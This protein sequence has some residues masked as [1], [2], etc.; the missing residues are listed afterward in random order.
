MTRLVPLMMLVYFMA[1]VDRTNVSLAKT[2]LEADLGI[3]AAAYGFGA[4]IFFL[5]YALLEIP[6]NLILHKVGA[7][8]WIA[9][10]AVTW[11]LLTS[12]TMFVDRE[13]SFYL[14][15]FLLGAAEAGLY[16]G[17]MYMITLWF[18]HKDRSTAVGLMMLAATSAFI[19]GNPAGGAIMGLDGSSG[20]HGWQWLFLLEGLVTVLVGV[21]IWFKLPDRPETASWLTAE[22]AAALTGR[23]VGEDGGIP[24]LRGN[25][26]AAFGNRV[27]L[28]AAAIY[29]FTQVSTYGATFF[30]PSVVE[31]MNVEGT[32]MIGLVAG[33]IAFG[34]FGGA[35]VMPRLHRRFGQG[36][37]PGII[38]LAS[39]G[40]LIA[41]AVFV[42]TTAPITRLIALSV[43]MLFVVGTVPIIWS[44]VMA[45][46]SGV[47][48]AAA[49]AFV[50][51]IGLTGGFVGAYLFGIA[52][53]M[54]GDA[55]SGFSVLGAAAIVILLLVPVLAG[56]VRRSRTPV[57]V[58]ESVPAAAGS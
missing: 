56:A 4:G 39:L 50:N 20:L 52:E 47:V 18:A 13:W 35:I 16:P 28:V 9:R 14:L 36:R 33:L 12:A 34:P 8:R 38:A 48:A 49:L 42:L 21:L 57:P 19:I 11:G 46:V 54:T 2:S 45:R 15:R 37:E 1:F 3:S 27:V 44:V 41:C 6:S 5:S 53:D 30:T 29:F 25:L 22:E 23:A 26:R 24:R 55:A 17:L 32:L 58:V 31:S 51:T 43:T 10:I 40:S 7:R